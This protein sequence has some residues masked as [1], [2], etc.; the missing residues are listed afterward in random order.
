MVENTA[1][2]KSGITINVDVSAKIRENMCEKRCIWNLSACNI[3]IGKCS[4]SVTGDSV[5][6]RDKIIEATKTVHAKTILTNTIAIKIY[7]F[8][9][10]L[11]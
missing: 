10:P 6:T 4:G 2:I 5:I 7:I 11:Y 8:Y 1:E 9:S 3:E